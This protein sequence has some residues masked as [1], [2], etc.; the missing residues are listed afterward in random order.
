MSFGINYCY[1]DT[2]IDWFEIL[3]LCERGSVKLENLMFRIVKCHLAARFFRLLHCATFQCQPLCCSKYVRVL[4]R[5]KC[6]PFF[7]SK[8]FEIYFLFKILVVHIYLNRFFFEPRTFYLGNRAGLQSLI[9]GV[10]LVFKFSC[11][12][13]AHSILKRRKRLNALL[14]ARHHGKLHTADACVMY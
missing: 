7:W 1:W 13:A 10:E 6:S 5:D 2:K 14:Y 12:H 9:T 3:S 4:C 8:R 11:L